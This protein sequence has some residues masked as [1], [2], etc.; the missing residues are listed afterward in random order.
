MRL[1]VLFCMILTAHSLWAKSVG[2][3][4]EVKGNAFSFHGKSPTTLKYGSKIHDM[5]DVMVEDGA[6]L[7]VVTNQEQLIHMSGGTLVKVYNG[8]VELKN[9][10]IWVDSNS[11]ENGMVNTSNS[12]A[13][14]SKGQFIYSF[15]N[16]KGKTQ[17]LVLQGDVRFSN[18]LEPGLVTKVSSGLFSMVD[19]KY[20]NGLPRTPTKVGL[21]SYK[22]TKQIFAGFKTIENSSFE[23]SIWGERKKT[24]VSSRGIASV[25]PTMPKA[26]SVRHAK[27]PKRGRLIFVQTMKANGGKVRMPASV[28]GPMKYYMKMRKKESIKR[29]PIKNKQVAPIRY[30]GIQQKKPTNE[31]TRF[32]PKKTRSVSSVGVKRVPASIQKVKMIRELKTS[33]FEKSLNQEI[34]KT[35]RNADEVNNLIDELKSYD[36]DFKKKY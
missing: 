5:A 7:S 28:N 21:K 29:K 3:V 2:R 34:P 15:D 23:E 18:S 14:Y 9:G 27:K 32:S 11:D 22:Q 6:T 25:Q 36:Q 35:R 33:G 10:H 17:I 1:I 20:E 13:Q 30:F 26:S 4:I 24:R 31:T 16:I 19:P 12:I 8:L